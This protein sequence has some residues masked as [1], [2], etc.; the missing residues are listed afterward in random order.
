MDDR[1]AGAGFGCDATNHPGGHM[2][3]H[4]TGKTDLYGWEKTFSPER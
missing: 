1:D 4:G 2:Q 3:T